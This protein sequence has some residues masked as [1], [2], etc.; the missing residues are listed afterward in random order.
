MIITSLVGDGSENRREARYLGIQ[1]M[2]QYSARWKAL[3]MAAALAVALTTTACDRQS[4]QLKSN[5]SEE[6][7]QQGAADAESSETPPDYVAE[8]SAFLQ[9]GDIDKA[10]AQFTK[11]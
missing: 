10:I 3:G 4:P 8:G 7:P 11:A 5:V 9:S 6:A 2:N 1:L